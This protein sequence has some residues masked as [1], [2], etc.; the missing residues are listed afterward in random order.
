MTELRVTLPDDVAERLASEAAERG[1]SAED[2][3]ADLLRQHVPAGRGR[4]L[5]FVGMFEGVPGAPSAAELQRQL[6]DG[7]DDGFGR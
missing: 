6:E 4:S 7:E 5:S 3:A 1:T 2:L